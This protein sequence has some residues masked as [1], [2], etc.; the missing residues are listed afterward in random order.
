MQ[1]DINYLIPDGLVILQSQ[2]EKTMTIQSFHNIINDL[3]V[4]RYNLKNWLSR[5]IQIV[6]RYKSPLNGYLSKNDI[7]ILKKMLKNQTLKSY[8]KTI[9]D[10]INTNTIFHYQLHDL[11]NL[12]ASSLFY[13]FDRPEHTY[14]T[15]WMVINEQK[16]L[17]SI[18]NNQIYASFPNNFNDIFDAQLRCSI[19][20]KQHLSVKYKSGEQNC[21]FIDYYQDFFS[22][23]NICCFSTL[24]PLSFD[25]H[26]MWGLYADS[27]SGISLQYNLDQLI[28]FI[29]QNIPESI[30]NF[31]KA[32]DIPEIEKVNPSIY[33][34]CRMLP[35][36]YIDE[37]NKLKWF[38]SYLDKKI[39]Q[40]N[41]IPINYQVLGN[42]VL[43][44]LTNKYQR[45]QY[46]QEVRLISLNY[47]MNSKAVI[48][49]PLNME[50]YINNAEV[51]NELQIHKSNYND[52]NIPFIKPT[53]ITL[54]WNYGK[55]DLNKELIAFANEQQIEL[56]Y[57]DN[58]VDY[59]N[60][61]FINISLE[62]TNQ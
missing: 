58:T 21:P 11:K 60:N 48:N 42:H 25:S 5:G 62:Q 24:D 22:A 33:D 18:K 15:K 50:T 51:Q 55:H 2:E 44:F 3:Y 16:K 14:L 9:H 27:G 40:I 34:H 7:S 52:N 6:A 54:G 39:N 56:G 4:L 35:V 47:I 41:N 12:I 23:A 17:D 29:S 19:A 26:N 30:D 1:T 59:I 8:H 57:L 43:D 53:K 49:H 20:I 46:E 37:N 28:A 10:L 61:K 31:R 38:E 32:L 45:W 36:Q 13:K